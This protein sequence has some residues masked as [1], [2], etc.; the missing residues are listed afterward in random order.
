[1][2]EAK[3]AEH[4]VEALDAPIKTWGIPFG[5]RGGVVIQEKTHRVG[6]N[7]GPATQ[8]NYLDVVFWHTNTNRPEGVN[9]MVDPKLSI[10]QYPLELLGQGQ[11][12]LSVE[13]K[14]ELLDAKIRQV[15]RETGD[16]LE[17]TSRKL[18]R[19]ISQW[20][21]ENM[22]KMSERMKAE[23]AEKA[24]T[25]QLPPEDQLANLA[26]NPADAGIGRS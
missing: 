8:E 3:P 10:D 13:Q 7:D 6:H 14:G 2:A 15:Q 22:R 24:R 16:S 9:T 20:G 12:G 23:A 25:A 4:A 18:N 5:D 26:K 11:E 19:E 17:E 21:I 1:M